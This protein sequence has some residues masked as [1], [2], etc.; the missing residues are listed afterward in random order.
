MD[1]K[2]RERLSAY[3]KL[4]GPAYILSEIVSTDIIPFLIHCSDSTRYSVYL[5]ALT[6]PRLTGSILVK[7]ILKHNLLAENFFE[8]ELINVDTLPEWTKLVLNE[9]TKVVL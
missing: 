8:T 6:F 5:L 1:P 3:S 4:V 9:Y 7:N 2:M